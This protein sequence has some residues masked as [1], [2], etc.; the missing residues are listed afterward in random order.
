[1]IGSQ[2]S[3]H[4]LEAQRQHAY[5]TAAVSAG[6][7]TVTGVAL[8][9][10]FFVQPTILATWGKA[11]TY[12]VGVILVLVLLLATSI[13]WWAA[14]ELKAGFAAAHR[15]IEALAQVDQEGA[16]IVAELER[17]TA[18]QARLNKL[19]A[20][21][22]APLIPVGDQVVV[23]P[24]VGAIDQE[25]IQHIRSNLLQR[26]EQERA[27]AALVDLTGV[28]EIE[29]QTIELFAQ[30]IAA[31]ELMGCRVVL[32]GISTPLAR[33][34]LEHGIDLP[35]RTQRDVKAGLEYAIELL[36]QTA[37]QS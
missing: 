13:T 14:R 15:R 22:S 28:T 1:M 18:E 23:I 29:R 20:T 19:V 16:Q 6:F 12:S 37:R 35:A 2:E 10:L 3:D 9:T 26:I 36:A 30:L 21:L 5:V 25:R 7:A 4:S 8:G 32:T 27:R 17:R 31:V 24:L 33:L 11:T 34:F